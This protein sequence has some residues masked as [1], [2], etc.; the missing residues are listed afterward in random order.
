MLQGSTGSTTVSGHFCF[1]GDSVRYTA[2]SSYLKHHFGT[3]VHKITL[4][5]GLTCPNRDGTKG[6]GGCIYCNSRGS[7]TGAAAQGSPIREQ[8]LAAQK[9]LAR[10]YGA[11]KYIAYF[12]SFCNTYG[13][14]ALL[15]NLYETAVSIPEVVGLAVATRPDCL[16]PEVLDLLSQ[17]AHRFMVWLELGLQTVHDRTLR[18]INRCHT[19]QDFLDGYHLA[20]QYPLLICVHV[21]IG[22]PGEDRQDVIETARS[23]SALAP[24]GIKI[25]SLYISRGTGLEKLYCDGRYTPLEREEFVARAC[26]M[27]EL[28]PAKTVVQRLTGD[29]DPQELVAPLW[30]LHKQET[31]RMIE[32]E[33]MRRG[34]RQG[35]KHTGVVSTTP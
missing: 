28:L 27:L 9:I 12:Q 15:K 33:L 21:I 3:R 10:R 1:R 6:F 19:W 34:S 11:E 14:F 5:A 13:Q 17:Y 35:A 30:T 22:L 4:D 24:D 31:L 18:L 26:D 2:F 25:H 23:L 20:R 8:A 16:S 29:P 32:N 7:G